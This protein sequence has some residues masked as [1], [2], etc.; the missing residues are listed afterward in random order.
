MRMWETAARLLHDQ[1]KSR[2]PGG[3]GCVPSHPV[4]RALLGQSGDGLLCG[5][6][7]SLMPVDVVIILL[8][9]GMMLLT[10][11]SQDSSGVDVMP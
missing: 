3:G 4:V 11:R 8:L 9:Q 10:L 5:F 7:T 6:L 2:G 1:H